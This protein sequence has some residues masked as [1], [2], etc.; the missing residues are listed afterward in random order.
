MV[1]LPDSVVEILQKKRLHVN[2][3]ISGF[4]QDEFQKLLLFEIMGTLFLLAE[5]FYELIDVRNIQNVIS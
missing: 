4:R 3:R 2:R 1:G 5:H